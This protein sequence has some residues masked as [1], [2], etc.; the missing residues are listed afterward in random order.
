V[1]A[2]RFEFEK[3]FW[4]ICAIYFTGVLPF[5]LR[6]RFVHCRAPAFDCSI[7]HRRGVAGD[8]VHP[9]RD[10]SRCAAR[11]FR[12]GIADVGSGVFANR[13]CARYRT[14]FGSARSRRAFSL[15][16]QSTLSGKPA[17]G[18]WSR[19]PGQPFRICFSGTG[20]LDLC[21]SA[22]FSRRRIP[23]QNAGGIV[24]SLLPSSSAFLARAKP[25][26]S[27]W[28][29]PARLGPGLRGRKLCLVVRCRRV[30]D[31]SD[32]ESLD[33]CRRVFARVR[34]TFSN[35]ATNP[36]TAKRVAHDACPQCRH[37]G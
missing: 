32:F 1:R 29:S 15:H 16:A 26:R 33:R 18:G 13:S 28:K 9:N 19:H 25:A 8:Y 10:R 17:D 23:A 2:T 4:I 37:E 12:S 21:L 7:D 27:V 3:R 11:F 36:K 31:R 6:P 35:H 5:R 34:R 22:D 30:V 20:E 14:T 24:S